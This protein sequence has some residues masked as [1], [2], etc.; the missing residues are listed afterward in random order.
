M[1][2]KIL[3][4]LKRRED[5][6]PKTHKQIGLTTGLYNSANFVNVM[7]NDVGIESYL[8]VVTDN[9]DI[10]REVTKY[11]PTH[12]IVEALWVVPEKFT[13]LSK[14]HPNVTWIVRLHS[15]MPFMAGEGIALDWLGEYSKFSN[16]LIA[17]NDPRM[18]SHTIE[19]LNLKNGWSDEEAARRVIY[20]PN[21]FP[22]QFQDRV[23]TDNKDTVDIACF[24]AVRPLKNHLVQAIAALRFADKIGK[25]LRFHINGGRI[26]MKVDTVMSNLQGLF[27]HLY[28]QDH[29]LVKHEWAPREEFLTICDQMDIGMQ[30]SFSETF[31]IVAADLISRG[32]PIV[33]SLEIPWAAPEFCCDPTDC[34]QMIETLNRSYRDPQ[35]NIR[36]NRDGLVEYVNKTKTIWTKFFTQES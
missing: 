15:D 3:F 25:K 8:E 13:V 28:H 9:N 5:F 26:E 34:D 6:N 29:L 2:P 20:L 4:L 33:G 11:R 7:L 36:K 22:E 24:G 1:T 30:V 31:N 14:L 35:L 10:D 17:C 19:F 16:I 12:V 32:V 23:F 18:Y 27:Q 21:Y